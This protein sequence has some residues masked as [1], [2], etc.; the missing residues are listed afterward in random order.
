M[1]LPTIAAEPTD[2]DREILSQYH[3]IEAVSGSY[4]LVRGP[5]KLIHYVGFL[6]E[7]LDL[8]AN[9]EKPAIWRKRQRIKAF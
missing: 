9:P 2:P 3:A 7:L 1:P 6:P 8:K 4:M 5:W